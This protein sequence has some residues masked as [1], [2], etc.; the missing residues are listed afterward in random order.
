M[1]DAP[2]E[3]LEGAP[4]PGGP[5]PAVAA[6][7]VVPL[8]D[9]ADG[10]EILL[11][12]RRRGGAFSGL[13]VFPG[14][15][16]EPVDASSPVALPVD[17]V[18]ERAAEVALARRAAQR[19]AAEEAGLGLD[20]TSMVVHSWWL[21]PPETPRRFST[22]FFLAPVT[23]GTAVVVDRAE[24]HEHRWLPPAA[25]LAARDA[26]EIGLAP[27][28]W[29]TVWQLGRWPDVAA[30]LADAAGRPPLE[31]R[32]RLA[33]APD[34]RQATLW[35][36]DAG[37]VDGDLDRPGPRRRL[38]VRPEGAWRVEIDAA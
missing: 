32:T 6:A 4:R 36:G 25:A 5:E 24:V 30:A 21:P 27:P 16:V 18:G 8:R 29:M 38:W 15:R 7:T 3:W 11:V 35:E 13:W 22:W 12:R 37:W 33:T 17:D 14:G 20:P 23:D 9:G 28:T 10:L 19:E 31:F 26:G 34:G 2:Y 1:A